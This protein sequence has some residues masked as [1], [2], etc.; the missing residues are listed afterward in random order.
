M[1]SSQEVPNSQPEGWHP[2]KAFKTPDQ[3][4]LWRKAK[5]GDMEA[6]GQ[7]IKLNLGLIN[8]F[9]NY[10]ASESFKDD[11]DQAGILAI[12]RS[13]EGFDPYLGFRF[14]TYASNWIKDAVDRELAKHLPGFKLP[15]GVK[16][17]IKSLKTTEEEIGSALGRMP[18]NNDIIQR[19]N[20]KLQDLIRLRA[21]D[22]LTSTAI[23]LYGREFNDSRDSPFSDP[24]NLEDTIFDKQQVDPAEAGV[25]SVSGE[26]VRQALKLLPQMQRRALVE[27]YGFDCPPKALNQLVED[28]GCRIEALRG[29]L[30]LAQSN[31]GLLINNRPDRSRGN[32]VLSRRLGLSANDIFFRCRFLESLAGS[33]QSF[34]PDLPGSLDGLSE[35]LTGLEQALGSLDDDHRRVVVL[36]AGMSGQMPITYLEI[37]QQMDIDQLGARGF[38]RRAKKQIKSLIDGN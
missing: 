5:A 38:D 11:I 26:E 12:W 4:Y 1:Q 14:S 29:L 23:S 2:E 35:R 36:A 15:K 31:L 37:S 20:Y 24:L 17:E 3:F 28:I 22:L 7:L 34:D 19:S 10:Y 25:E 13:I 8:R 16:R 32:R 21:T 6:C 9:T 18:T 30:G 27:R 33:H